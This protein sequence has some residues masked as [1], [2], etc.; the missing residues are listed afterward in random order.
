MDARRREEAIRD[1]LRR[2]PSSH[3]TESGGRTL[4]RAAPEPHQHR[5][6]NCVEVLASSDQ[7]GPL[8]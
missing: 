3:A 4:L 1:L 6:P 8:T 2:H 5:L 7:G